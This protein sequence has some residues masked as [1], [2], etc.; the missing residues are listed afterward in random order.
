VHLSHAQQRLWLLDQVTDGLTAYNASRLLRLRG[1]LDADRLEA[2][3][4][5]VVDHH[6]VLRTHVKSV[7]G[8]PQ[9]VLADHVDFEME[10]ADVSGRPDAEQAALHMAKELVARQFDLAADC[11]L[12]ALLIRVGPDDHLL[13]VCVHHIAS[14]GTS[15]E[16]LLADLRR[17]YLRRPD[18][19][20]P[21]R[22]ELQYGDV[23]AWELHED[24]QAVLRAQEAFWTEALAGAPTV[25][26][27]PLD[28]TRPAV[29]TYAGARQTTILPEELS[30]GIAALARSCGATPFMVLLA[31]FAG[32]LGRLSGQSE[33]IVGTPVNR[34]SLPELATVMGMMSDTLPLRLGLGG[35]PTVEELVAR[36]RGVVGLASSN[37]DVSFD[38]IVELVHPHR[39]PSRPPLVQVIINDVGA[40][41]ENEEHWD[42]LEVTHVEMDPG[43]S[44]VDLTLAVVRRENGRTEL[45]WEWCTD[46]WGEETVRRF[47]R[48]FETLLEDAVADPSHRLSS[49]AL[50]DVDMRRDLLVARNDTARPVPDGC[51]HELV[52]AQ[53]RRT[54]DATAVIASDGTRLTF[55]EVDD[56]ADA[57]ASR[58]QAEGVRPGDRVALCLERTAHLLPGILGILKAGG[59]YV[60]ID[61]AHPI[62]RIAYVLDD[63]GVDIVVASDATVRSLPARLRPVLLD[64]PESDVAQDP[65]TPV[66]TD[67]SSLAYIMYTSG[68]TGRPKGVMVAHRGVV[69][70]LQ[71]MAEHPGLA[72][73]EVMVGVTTTAFDVSVP[74]LFLPLLT[75]GTLALA[76]TQVGRDPVALARFIAEHGASVMQATPTT[77]QMLIESGWPGWP[78]LRIVCGGEGYS[79]HL[80][81]E[82]VARVEEVWNYYGP[83]ETTIW[84]VCARLDHSSGDP[85]PIGRPVAN[86]SCY[87]LDEHRLPVPDGV[88]GEL[89]IGGTGVAPG[90]WLRPDLTE[91][92]FVPDPFSVDAG[93]RLYRTG[94]LARWRVDGQLVFCGRM[95]HQVKL[96]GHRIELGEIEAVLADAPGV[97][98]AVAVIRTDTPGDSRLVAYVV[99]EPT[100][101][102]DAL[103]EHLR[104]RL[105]QP[106]LP[107]TIVV[108]EE[109]P[110]TANNKVD[111]KSLPRPSVDPV[112]VVAPSGD[113][114]ERMAVL[115]GELLG[116]PVVGATD[117][118]FELGGH[119]LLA[120]R[121][122]AKVSEELG[123]EADLATLFERPVLADYVAALGDVRRPADDDRPETSV[124]TVGA[125]SSGPDSSGPD[126]SSTDPSST[127]SGHPDFPDCV[128]APAT[129]AQERMWLV[130]QLEPGLGLSNIPV[131]REV[132]GPVDANALEG[133]L[134]VLIGRHAALR[135]GLVEID[136]T[137][138]QV[139]R[140]TGALPLRLSDTSQADDPWDAAVALVQESALA[141]FDTTLPPLMRAHLVRAGIDDGSGVARWLLC[142]T[143]H[144]AIADN[145]S[146]LQLVDELRAEYG[147]LVGAGR[148]ERD[149]PPAG[150]PS[151]DYA[152]F[153]VWQREL[154]QLARLESDL[155]YWRTKLAGAPQAIEMP[156]DRARPLVPSHRGGRAIRSLADDLV[157]AIRRTSV[158]ASTTLFM[159]LLASWAS[160][161]ALHGRQDEVVIGVPSSGRPA[162]EFDEVVGLFLN[163]LPVRIPLGSDSTFSTV[164]EHTRDALVGAMAHRNAPFDRIVD[165]VRGSRHQSSHP[166]F[167][168]MANIQTEPSPD[169]EFGGAQIHPTTVDWGWSRFGDLSLLVAERGGG[170]DLLV[171]Y[172]HDVFDGR[173]V[174]QL[175]E[176]LERLLSIVVDDPDTRLTGGMLAGPDDLQEVVRDFNEDRPATTITRSVHELVT[177]RAA[178]DPQGVAVEL[179]A[180]VLTYSA[181]ES[182]ANRLA[183]HLIGLGAGPGSIVGICL[184]RSLELPVALLGVLKS[185]AAFLPL[186]PGAPDDRLA[187]MLDDAGVAIVVTTEG[188]ADRVAGPDRRQVLLDEEQGTLRSLAD[189]PPRVPLT[190]SDLAYVI[191][192]SGST[193]VPKGVA[194]EHHGVS[195]LAEVVA[196]T[197]ELES[198]SRVLQFASFAFD[199]SVTELLVPLTVGA[200]VVLAETEVLASGFALL[201]LLASA[202][203]TVATLPPSLLAVLPDTD[204]PHLRTLC[205]AG[206]ACPAEVVRRW[207]R[208][209][210]FLNGYGPTEATVAVS[211]AILDGG[212]AVDAPIVPLGRPIANVL[213]Y[214]VD[215]AGLPVPVGV[216]GELWVGGAGVARGY[217]G[218]PELTAERFVADPFRNDGRIFKTGDRVRWRA[219][220]QLEFLGRLDNQVKLRGFR[221]ELGEIESV[222]ADH[223]A[224]LDAAAMV[225]EDVP[226]SP[227]LVAYVVVGP[228]YSGA[229]EPLRAWARRRMPEY[230]VPATVVVMAELPL[231]LNGKVDRLALPAPEREGTIGG[232]GP[233]EPEASPIEAVVRDLWRELLGVHDLGL[234]EDL[235]DVGV[236]S[237]MATRAAARLRTEFGVELAIPTIFETPTVSG[238]AMAVLV[239]L[240]DSDEP[241]YVDPEGS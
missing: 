168:V 79:A 21:V 210:R 82:L 55:R 29:Q 211:Y 37:R 27:L 81:G 52:E 178:D 236:D 149:G 13:A 194:I 38:R 26:D 126:P 46:L 197:F 201:D 98:R 155:E 226:G 109:F 171:E 179:G 229:T 112:A 221:I 172:N 84:S 11:L 180:G 8:T 131:V 206:E 166:I 118:F 115:W 134:G 193:G 130:D 57:V 50:L 2:A 181:L 65:R 223:P 58:L 88:I 117:D 138:R 167:Q 191:Y 80:A 153:A 188:V 136:G 69:N 234:D 169:V 140:R 106:M 161:L 56:A 237:L 59:A 97:D 127:E 162:P 203:I 228:E 1:P 123:V 160:V 53:V 104:S 96:R 231:T 157:M 208:G 23:V 94:D 205:S 51:L 150:T 91:E 67:S 209:R 124:G 6:E 40:R 176:R 185:G 186:D 145:A 70:L 62:D 18:H 86:T 207:G 99:G 43:T 41:Q 20:A 76:S 163:T 68:S 225:R 227:R 66:V 139:V 12:R 146:V 74:D 28:G 61:P 10:R 121:L 241:L 212:L 200:T 154:A 63:A 238:V 230:M 90:Y 24:R 187:F 125:D 15:R 189:H 184:E 192:T 54:P 60:P 102:I 144:H 107:S 240:A 129:S 22:P 222:L 92:R 47:A 5:L 195:N 177:D 170:L 173:S 48:Q 30:D 147:K 78:G 17:N 35:D 133:A 75:G 135:T 19:A 148:A 25:V 39:D 103:H 151:S 215:V 16:V 116:V 33:V 95:D 142:L 175:V 224:V 3:L 87:V 199:A 159:T 100:L 202:S 49:L 219:D 235:F 158:E 182:A 111:R 119:S 45:V 232:P 165:A 105:P 233:S 213:A 183:H 214:V 114:E 190:G 85:I 32:F 128:V 132:T 36:V 71:V 137:L 152:A 44:Q 72:P 14:D 108:V 216:P 122:A 196:E 9:A 174:E 73:G 220:G 156:F 93:A 7:H 239:A 218:R 101:E 4:S 64:S 143:L 204:L 42:D 217:L 31:A 120:A 77:W 164:L 110:L 34:R 83:T 89:Y 141:P 113:L 198:A